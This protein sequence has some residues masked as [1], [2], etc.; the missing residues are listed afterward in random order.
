MDEILEVLK[1]IRY[2]LQVANWQRAGG[3]RSGEPPQRHPANRVEKRS[4][5]GQVVHVSNIQD[6]QQV[7]NEM[8]RQQNHPGKGVA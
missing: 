2:E 7:L 8:K 5:G 6:T 4:F 3:K 1:D